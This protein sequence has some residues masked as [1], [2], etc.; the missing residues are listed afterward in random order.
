M[1]VDLCVGVLENDY[2]R[3]QVIDKCFSSH[4]RR[5]FLEQVGSA[6]LDCLLKFARA[7]KAVSR[8]LK[9]MDHNSNESHV[10]AVGGKK[11]DRAWNAREARVGKG[12]FR[13]RCARNVGG[14]RNAGGTRGG[15]KPKICFGCGREGYFTGEKTSRRM[16]RHIRDL[17]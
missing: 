6:I 12:S 10:N 13:A 14:A 17:F 2:I 3:N 1:C 5:K 15:R 4:L 11:S 7:Q 8:Q 9:E 16:A